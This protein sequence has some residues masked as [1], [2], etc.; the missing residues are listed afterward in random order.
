MAQTFD[1]TP[2]KYFFIEMLT[3]DIP[4]EWAI[5]DLID[6][7]VDGARDKIVGKHKDYKKPN[8]YKGF[9]VGLTLNEK[10]FIIKDNC[11]G[12]SKKAASDYT[13]KFG[14]PTDQSNFPKGSV[15]RFGVGLKR[16]MFKI[17]GYFVVETKCGK[18]HFF[19]EH[20]IEK[21]SKRTE[22]T[23][24]F[25]DVKPGT[26]Y[27]FHKPVLT[28]DGTYIRVTKLRETVKQDFGNPMFKKR[29]IEEVQRTL[30]YSLTNELELKIDGKKLEGKPVELLAS[31]ALKPYFLEEKINDVTVRIYAGVGPPNPNEA[32][33]YIFCNDRLMVEKDKSNL[34]G[35]QGD[36]SVK[37]DEQVQKFH[38]KVAMFRGIVFF[39]ADRSSS[40]PMTTTKI[41]V[42]INS[43]IY[44][45]VR[46]KMINAMK[47]VLAYLNKLEN[48]QQRQAIV[49]QSEEKDVVKLD[50]K[51]LKDEFVF[52]A[53]KKIT[54]PEKERRITYSVDKDIYDAV[55]EELN[56]GTA[57]EVGL[58]TF[59]YFVEMKEL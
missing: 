38:N 17:G 35:W 4:L 18:D 41:G 13:F 12:F 40:L 45:T 47:K 34:T 26:R 6:N 1:A 42:D 43:A 50:H 2:S 54:I 27:P 5:L 23:F 19:V 28:E 56:V 58:A 59:N 16:G 7:S 29:L 24:D 53:I 51:K 14:R 32:G 44:K 10:E 52:P 8:A 15:G 3:R 57:P 31:S 20:D 33:W 39:D 22:W 30:S 55:R 46:S 11:G 49:N 21:W 48:D 37:G 25:I 36:E 9:K